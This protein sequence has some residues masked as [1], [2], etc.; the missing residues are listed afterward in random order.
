V[1]ETGSQYDGIPVTDGFGYIDERFANQ[2]YNGRKK[3]KLGR[4]KGK[5]TIWQRVNMSD[6]AWKEMEPH[7]KERLE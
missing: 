5:Y 4:T 1:V 2:V 7:F 6:A 3:I